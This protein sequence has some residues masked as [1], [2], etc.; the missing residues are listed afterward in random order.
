MTNDVVVLF[1]LMGLLALNQVVMRVP[2]LFTRAWVF[3][4]LVSVDIL[5]GTAVIVWGL[6]GFAHLPA[7]SWVMGLM[8]FLHAAQDLA[9]RQK[10]LALQA[11]EVAEERK[12]KVAEIVGKER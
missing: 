10:R 1:A 3:F 7:V 12:R 11:E 8:F 9:I 5:A 6:P 4:G 2:A